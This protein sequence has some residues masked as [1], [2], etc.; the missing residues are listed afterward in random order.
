[1]NLRDLFQN[2][3]LL[4]TIV[5]RFCCKQLGRQDNEIVFFDTS[6]FNAA[7]DLGIP[8]KLPLVASCPQVLAELAA[9]SLKNK[10]RAVDL[11]NTFAALVNDRLVRPALELAKLEI[12][13]LSTNN[14]PPRIYYGKDKF[15]SKIMPMLEKLK[16]GNFDD[17]EVKE[18]INR[19][20]PL[21]QEFIEQIKKRPP[22]ASMD[23]VDNHTL[24]ELVPKGQ[25][26]VDIINLAASMNSFISRKNAETVIENQARMPHFMAFLLAPYALQLIYERKI[27]PIKPKRGINFDMQISINAATFQTFICED[28]DGSAFFLGLFPKKTVKK[29][30]QL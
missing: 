12:I 9:T 23:T 2:C 8:S 21:K 22:S 25:L 10:E 29:F 19:I 24:L 27:D 4:P 1:M 6:S 16:S 28:A 20:A 26:L 7:V 14:D 17:S 3:L 11:C 13:A 15:D 5:T 18:F 30:H